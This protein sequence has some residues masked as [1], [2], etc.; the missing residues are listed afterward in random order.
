M[1]DL[2]RLART[3]AVAA[4]PPAEDAA[5]FDALAEYDRLV[6][7]EQTLEHRKDILRPDTPE[8]VEAN[9][10]HNAANDKAMEAWTT[11]RDIPATTQAGLFA[12][13]QS[14]VRFMAYL[15]EDDLWEGEWQAIKA[16]V[17]RIAGDV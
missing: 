10:V 14:I 7:I 13:L 9:K 12:K 16:D 8:A 15:Q 5:L 2:E 11:A 17:Q 3:T 6:G 4:M 1:F